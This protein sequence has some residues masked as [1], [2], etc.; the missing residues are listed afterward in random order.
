M[1]R[2]P[3]QALADPTRRRIIEI[4]SE[5]DQTVNEI[6]GNFSISR[7]AISKQ[8]KILE[9]SALVEISSIGRERICSISLG[10]LAEVSDWVSAYEQFWLA[11]MDRLEKH[12]KKK[13]KK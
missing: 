1:R 7:P 11:K 3:W 8:L 5:G 6:A 13:S 2:D 10:P 9:E 12:L 4:L